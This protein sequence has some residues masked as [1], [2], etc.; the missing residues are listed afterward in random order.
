MAARSRRIRRQ[1]DTPLSEWRLEW[2]RCDYEWTSFGEELIAPM[3]GRTVAH[4]YAGG[5][6]VRQ[7]FTSKERMPLQLVDPSGLDWGIATWVE[8]GVAMV[9]Y[10]FEGPVGS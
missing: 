8:N 6:G 5:D 3:G 2:D 7:Q 4:G 10:Y 1:P 9:D